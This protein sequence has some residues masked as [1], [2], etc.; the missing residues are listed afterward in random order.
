MGEIGYNRHEYLYELNYCDILCIERG[1]HRRHRDIWSATRWG[2]YYTMLATCGSDN[3][4]KARIYKPYDLIQF[5]WEREKVEA[6][7]ISEDDVRELQAVMDAMNK[8]ILEHAKQ[9]KQSG[10]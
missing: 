4:H 3:L 10:N 9:K 1:Y 5:P 2:T 7:S 6:P 8:E